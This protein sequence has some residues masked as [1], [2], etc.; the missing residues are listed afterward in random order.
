MKFGEI[1]VIVKKPKK[2]KKGNAHYKYGFPIDAFNDSGDA[3]GESV[4][5][6]SI[7]TEIES[8]FINEDVDTA[9]DLNKALDTLEPRLKDIVVMRVKHDMTFKEIGKEIGTGTDRARQLF[10]RALR[11]LRHPKRGIMTQQDVDNYNDKEGK[12]LGWE[13]GVEY[14]GVQENFADRRAAR[15]IK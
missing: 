11:K 8:M 6:E 1:E 10:Q 14:P 3:V 4:F 7:R 12:R 13:P 15:G 9:L 5:V 2:K